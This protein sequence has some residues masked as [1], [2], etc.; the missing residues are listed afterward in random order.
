MLLKEFFDLNPYKRFLNI[1][2]NRFVLP[3]LNF[4]E[5]NDPEPGKFTTVHNNLVFSE[6]AGAF[7][8][9]GTSSHQFLA[10]SLT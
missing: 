8:D 2:I 10:N 4:V 5:K 3:P 9:V 6:T 1:Y 7:K